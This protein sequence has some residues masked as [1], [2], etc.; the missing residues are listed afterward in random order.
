MTKSLPKLCLIADCDTAE[1]HLPN[2]LS[3]T[4]HHPIWIMLRDKSADNTAIAQTLNTILKMVYYHPHA[5]LSI[6]G[7]CA[8]YAEL[9]AD[10][11]YLGLHLP[12]NM[13][14]ATARQHHPKCH[15][16]GS[17]HSVFDTKRVAE[18]HLNYVTISPVFKTNSH[19]NTPPLD[20]DSITQIQKRL[21]C[22]TV[23]LGGINGD[24]LPH[25]MTY[26]F[27]S[28]ACIQG[29][30]NADSLGIMVNALYTRP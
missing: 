16:G 6:N 23:A 5:Q 30:H 4:G 20:S 14:W 8:G 18:T 24:T 19:P 22:Q 3:I 9:M 26:N 17:L 2:A 11:P 21:S 27:D 25:A 15:M 12:T 10:H 28:Y 29:W 1:N 7:G 13:D